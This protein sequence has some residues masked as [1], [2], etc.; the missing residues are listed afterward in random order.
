[1]H[2]F[3]EKYIELPKFPSEKWAEYLSNDH[4]LE[5]AIF[6]INNKINDFGSKEKID[7]LVIDQ[8]LSKG[9][10]DTEIFLF[11]ISLAIVYLV[12]TR[13]IKEAQSIS[14][15]GENLIIAKLILKL[16]LNYK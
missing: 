11:F 7:M 15:I 13:Q 14:A 9:H 1:M 3:I 8:A 6:R 4:L 10:E 5:S 2:I 12:Q 16:I